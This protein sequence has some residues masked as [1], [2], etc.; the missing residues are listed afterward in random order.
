M[1]EKKRVAGG[2][3]RVVS[4]RIITAVSYL[5]YMVKIRIKQIITTIEFL[6]E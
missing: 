6:T 1:R 5:K 2:G 3:R 4:S